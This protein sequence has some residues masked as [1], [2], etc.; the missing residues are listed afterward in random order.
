MRRTDPE[1]K[2]KQFCFS[3]LSPCSFM[4]LKKYP[5]KFLEAQNGTLLNLCKYKKDHSV[6]F[7][8]VDVRK[9]N[10]DKREI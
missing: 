4:K 10:G 2:I 5:L 6:D 7:D 9:I 8:F 3:T 1:Y